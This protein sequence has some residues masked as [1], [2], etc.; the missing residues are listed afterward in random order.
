[1]KYIVTVLCMVCAAGASAVARI[2][3]SALPASGC[4]DTEVSTNV[5]FRTSGRGV[6]AL[7][8]RIEYTG[9]ESNCVEV[10]F[11]RDADGNG[12]LSAGEM[13]LLL[14]WR[15]G[16]RFVEDVASDERVYEDAE[17]VSGRRFLAL[18][19]ATDGDLVPRTAKFTC[20]SGPCFASLAAHPLRL[21]VEPRQGCTAR[22]IRRGRVVRGR[23]LR[24]QFQHQGEVAMIDAFSMAY[25]QLLAR[26]AL[27]AAATL[28]AVL[29]ARAES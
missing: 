13:R 14:G 2:E 22:R 18:S 9:S 11:G 24:A 8:V 27:P 5:A 15:G 28:L 10:A 20:E 7:D 1:M 17:P 12:V 4:A 26:I 29:A 25:S 6:K 23:E 3:V 19:V 16:R 21:V